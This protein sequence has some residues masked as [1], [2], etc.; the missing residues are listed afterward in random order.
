[1]EKIQ[2]I[3]TA[4]KRVAWDRIPDRVIKRYEDEMVILKAV[5]TGRELKAQTTHLYNLIFAQYGYTKP[6]L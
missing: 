2:T 6:T 5:Y 1:M 4:V 3:T